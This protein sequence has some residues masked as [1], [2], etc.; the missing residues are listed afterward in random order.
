MLATGSSSMP[1]RYARLQRLHQAWRGQLK[2]GLALHWALRGASLGLA[3][4]LALALALMHSG[5]LV[6]PAYLRLL[7]LAASLGGML[8]AAS[9]LVW[10]RSA[11]STA[12]ELDRRLGLQERL[13]TAVELHQR[14]WAAGPMAEL[15]LADALQACRRA[16]LGAAVDVAAL[17]LQALIFGLLLL[18]CVLPVRWGRSS[19][20]SAE[21]RQA[22]ERAVDAETARIEALRS[23]IAEAEGLAPENREALTRALREAEQQLAEADSVEAAVAALT[24]GESRLRELADAQ[25]LGLAAALQAAG[26]HLRQSSDLGLSALGAQLAQGDFQGATQTLRQMD[27]RPSSAAQAEAQARQLEAAAETFQ[28]ASPDLAQALR[29]AASSLRS[30]DAATTRQRLADA[31]QALE[32]AAGQALQA[33]AAEGAAEALAQAQARVLQ[34][35]GELAGQA[36]WQSQGSL[37]G[38]RSDGSQGQDGSSATAGQGEGGGAGRGESTAA[39]TQGSSSGSTPIGQGN[40]PGDGGERPYQALQPPARLGGVDGLNLALPESGEAGELVLGVGARTPG[41]QGEAQVP[42]TAV[43]GQYEAA[44]RVAIDNLQPPP[45][46]EA[47]VRQY[48]SSLA[49]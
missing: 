49:P 5:G 37:D 15:Q 8:G 28:A 32:S 23:E 9:A 17:R 43:F 24:A 18:A 21:L 31:A 16:R 3:G 6:L 1:A 47:L 34:A 25:A 44:A 48:F 36:P 7:I 35:T 20:E 38:G 11:L 42:Y 22:L 29:E 14:G 10:P 13:S 26:E 40:A 12:V 45:H 4:G 30:G 46:L 39:T 33:Q 19:F 2:L 27:M 41:A